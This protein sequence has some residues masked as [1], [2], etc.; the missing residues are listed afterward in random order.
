MSIGNYKQACALLQ[1]QTCKMFGGPIMEDS[2][3]SEHEPGKK[4]IFRAY[5][6]HPETGEKIYPKNGNVFPIWVDE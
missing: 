3:D 6:V 5:Y 1:Q 4:L 2:K